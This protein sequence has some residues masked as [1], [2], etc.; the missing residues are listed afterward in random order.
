M[1]VRPLTAPSTLAV[2]AVLVAMASLASAGDLPVHSWV[3]R[4]QPR[5]DADCEAYLREVAA[6]PTQ[7]AVVDHACGE[8]HQP[9]RRAQIA[10]LRRRPD[11]G[12]R[13]VV[14][15][16]SIGE[17]EDYRWYWRSSYRPERRL[18]GL[19][20]GG[21]PRWLGEENPRWDGNYKVRF[22]EPSWQQILVEGPFLGPGG[23]RVPSYLDRI[24]EAGFDGVY[25]DIV[26]GYEDFLDENPDARRQMVDLVE[27]IRDRG[28]ARFRAPEAEDAPHPGFQVI[29]QN[30]S[31]LLT[32][33]A[34]GARYLQAITGI[35]QEETWFLS[36]DEARDGAESAAIEARLDRARAA[37]LLVLTVDYAKR[38]QTLREVYARARRK[39]YVPYVT[40]VE[41]D[42]ITPPP[43]DVGWEPM[44]HI[45]PVLS[46]KPSIAVGEPHPGTPPEATPP[47][48]EAQVQAAAHRATALGTT[49]GVVV[50]MSAGPVGAVV[51]AATG[52]VL[53]RGLVE[54]WV[55]LRAA[56][57]R[58]HAEG[59]DEVLRLSEQAPPQ[60]R[61]AIESTG[62]YLEASQRLREVLDS[63]TS[64]QRSQAWQEYR[65]A[66]GDYVRSVQEGTRSAAGAP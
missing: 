30:A 27:R 7:L 64:E 29:A 37:G 58:G 62:S 22:W 63:G 61:G 13:L 12:R 38:E 33:G 3:Y 39:G 46:E 45:L 16:M 42:R 47:A 59:H 18:L 24:L 26:D 32:D 14:A 1:L 8:E 10:A 23:T 41:L 21:N 50:G 11:G 44:F 20:R 54:V 66:W 48:R 19:R 57:S 35:A 34:L 60:V 4:L 17:A 9:F 28:R 15:Y 5:D 65:E 55:R 25:L 56:F 40:R 31:E 53:G 6:T 43:A 2:L 49:V 51:G 36:H 52:G